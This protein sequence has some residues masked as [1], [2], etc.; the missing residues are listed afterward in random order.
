MFS[1]FLF[2]QGNIFRQ[3]IQSTSRGTFKVHYHIP[4]N[5]KTNPPARDI[6]GAPSAPSDAAVQH[7]ETELRGSGVQ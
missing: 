4:Y 7:M 6:A 1:R 5:K 2:F 3:K